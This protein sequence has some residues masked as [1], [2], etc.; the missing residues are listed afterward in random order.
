MRGGPAPW[1]TCPSKPICPHSRM[2]T[3]A[4]T[5]T[6]ATAASTLP[7]IA[8]EHTRTKKRSKSWKLQLTFVK[9]LKRSNREIVADIFL[10]AV[11]KS[12]GDITSISCGLGGGASNHCEFIASAEQLGARPKEKFDAIKKDF[13]KGMAST[14]ITLVKAQ[15]LHKYGERHV[16]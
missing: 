15:W 6:A 12:I 8:N 11:K 14:R 13:E 9:L 1:S 4:T 5:I 3:A 10:N 7:E 2:Y 16:H